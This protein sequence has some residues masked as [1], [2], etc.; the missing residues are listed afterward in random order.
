M[1]I[2]I[3]LL[4]IIVCLYILIDTKRGI[5]L[6]LIM[7]PLID[8]FWELKYLILNVRPP[9]VNGVLFPLVIFLK[10][11]LSKK[12]NNFNSPF[13]IAIIFYFFYQFYP[14]LLITSDAGGIQAVNYFFRIIHMLIGFFIFQ[15]FFHER[16]DFKKL[17]IALIIAG[18]TPLGIS[19]YQNVLGGQIRTEETIGGLVRN[20]GLYHDAYT[21]RFYTLQTLAALILYGAYFVN[22]GKIWLKGIIVSIGLFCIYTIYRIYSKA[23]YLILAQWAVVWYVARKRIIMLVLLF[24]VGLITVSLSRF[25]WIEE[26]QVVY[27]KE[28]GALEGEEQVE[29]MFQG[30]VGGWLASIEYWKTQ[31]LHKK[32]FGLGYSSIGAHND[33]LRALFGT[34]IIGLLLYVILLGWA[35]IKA[36]RNCIR[37]NSPLNIMALML[38]FMWLIDAMGLS[39]GGY[40]GYQ[41]LVWGF[42]GLAFRGVSG[43]DEHRL[44]EEKG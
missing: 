12:N 1:A 37:D 10:L 25:T 28:V 23:G 27:S 11:L 22:Q 16:E 34:G 31:P 30:R 29:M 13:N 26:I 39:P 6:A 5:L 18:L 38:L 20:I 9:E 32:L 7:R 42:V 33:F 8:I 21:L 17:L 14:F 43:L 3:N 19:F 44:T 41:L 40:P 35:L 15:K 24:V 4:I 2:I 36:L